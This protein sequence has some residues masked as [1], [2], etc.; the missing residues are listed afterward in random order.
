MLVDGGAIYSHRLQ[1]QPIQKDCDNCSILIPKNFYLGEY[2]PVP[3][4]A[5]H[6]IEVL[7]ENGSHKTAQEILSHIVNGRL[8]VG[9]IR[10]LAEFQGNARREK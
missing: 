9:V 6:L 3:R 4:W 8:P 2:I 5:F 10:A 1:L 7:R